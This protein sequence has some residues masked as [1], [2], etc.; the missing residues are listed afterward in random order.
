MICIHNALDAHFPRPLQK[1]SRRMAYWID[2]ASG[3]CR[4]ATDFRAAWC[5]L[6]LK[7]HG[8]NGHAPVVCE[9][10]GGV[11]GPQ[12]LGDLAGATG[13]MQGGTLPG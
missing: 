11:A 1:D 3:P 4:V 2:M 12:A 9:G 8:C 6:I 10:Q 13:E 5:G 7:V